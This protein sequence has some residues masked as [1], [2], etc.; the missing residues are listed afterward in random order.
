MPS[1]VFVGTLGFLVQWSTR[2]RVNADTYFHLRLGHEFLK[3]WAPWN[4]GSVTPY[5]TREW[6]PSQ[7]LSQVAMAAVENLWGLEGVVW[8]SGAVMILYTVVVLRACRRESSL[9]VAATL[10]IV[11]LAA[12]TPSL[13]ARP[14]VISFVL[15][16][17]TVS[18][19]MRTSRDGR[20]RWWLIP[21]T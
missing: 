3:H 17:V 16:A 13:S 11:V 5:A 8:L 2:Q 7:W 10:T 1:L 14:Q 4:P 12:S 15:T 21:V 18:A 9:L 20:V 6:L 19:W